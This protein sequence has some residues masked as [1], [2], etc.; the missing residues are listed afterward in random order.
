MTD[1]REQ[2]L[3]MVES[4]VRPSDV[5]DRR[6]I[7]AMGE[8]G[9][10][11]YVPAGDRTT[12]YRDEAIPME[13]SKSATTG[14][15][16]MAPRAFAKLLQLADIGD[17]G[18]VLVVGCG[19]GYSLAV[20]AR[21]ARK[22]VGVEPNEAWANHARKALEG[23]GV[24]NVEVVVGGCGSGHVPAGPYDAILVEGA[25]D[26]VSSALLDQLKD[27]GRLVGVLG[28]GPQGKAVVWQRSGK[29]Y[30]M[31]DGFDMAAPLLP[32]LQKKSVF[33]L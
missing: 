13:P 12:A 21:M 1:I 19:M 29:I 15:Q 18:V 31:R 11:Q 25:F 30:A 14:R 8:I 9:R 2:R 23:D 27:G 33:T 22:V 7:R 16:V 17:K 3:N 20:V 32:G 24:S 5:T 6:I 10:E 4:Q 28:S 26:D